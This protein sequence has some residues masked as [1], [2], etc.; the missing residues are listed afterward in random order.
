MDKQNV[1]SCDIIHVHIDIIVLLLYLCIGPQILKV[2]IHAI[3][4]NKHAGYMSFTRLCKARQCGVLLS[5]TIINVIQVVLTPCHTMFRVI[6]AGVERGYMYM[7][8][9]LVQG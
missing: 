1:S 2:C 4:Y 7:Q 8:Q 5:M 6:Y 9:S 3:T